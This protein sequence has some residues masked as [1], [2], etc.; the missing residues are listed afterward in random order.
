M[1]LENPK[2][3][4]EAVTATA[5]R[6]LKAQGYPESTRYIYS[7]IWKNL[8]N[9]AEE[10]GKMEISPE[11]GHEFLDAYKAAG[12]RRYGSCP[13]NRMIPAQRA[14]LSLVSF[15][16]DGVWEPFHAR[17]KAVVPPCGFATDFREYFD[18]LKDER[19]LC[20]TTVKYRKRC[21]GTFLIFLQDKGVDK[22]AALKPALFA[23][24]FLTQKHLEPVSLEA[25]A[26]GIRDF[27]RFLY[28]RGTL[29]QD[30]TLQVPHFRSFSDQHVPTIWTGDMVDSL[31][32]SVDRE[33]AAGKRDYAILLL[34]CRLGMRTGDIR[35]LR[36]ESLLWDDARIEYTQSKTGVRI[37]LPLTDEVGH[38]L[39]DYLLHGRP[40]SARREV[41]L[42]LK[43]PYRPLSLTFSH[44]LK[45]YQQP[46]E[47]V[48]PGQ[49]AGMHSLR[50][51]L[52]TRLLANGVSL[53]NIAGVLGH[54][55]LNTT[56]IYAKVDISQL[57]AAAID[58]EELTHA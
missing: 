34:A 31:L 15:A 17:K 32:G 12:V 4:L 48:F 21:V 52:A 18:H 33:C 36:L 46:H 54:A 22:W 50:H 8:L 45:K 20:S 43:A 19:H 58:P 5:L 25:I 6:A 47:M 35:A 40:S 24:F 2:T 42:R 39:I 10:R 53:E 3:P 57:R 13:V 11:L 49:R 14:V 30:W 26:T 55:S 16:A 38:A 7:T 1:S 44:V 37:A 23:E 29:N 27:I 41:F 56:R 28:V 9:F 51:T